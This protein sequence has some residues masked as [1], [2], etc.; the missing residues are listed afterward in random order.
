MLTA[1]ELLDQLSTSQTNIGWRELVPPGSVSD[2]GYADLLSQLEQAQAARY[3]TCARGAPYIF[4]VDNTGRGRLVQGCCNNW[5]CP[6]CGHLRALHEYGRMVN[7]A[8]ALTAAGHRLYFLTLT[9]RG[10]TCSVREAEENYLEWTNRFLTAYRTKC[11]R[12]GG[13]WHYSSVTERQRRRHP[14]SHYLITWHPSEFVH[15]RKHE[16]KFSGSKAKHNCIDSRQ[17]LDYC[18]SSGLG[19]E[20]DLTEVRNPTGCAVYIGKYLFKSSIATPW[21]PGWRRVRYSKSWPKLPHIAP[22]L[23]FPLLKLADW[24]RMAASCDI[25]YADSQITLEAAYARHITNV[26]CKST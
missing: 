6:R 2:K 13:A 11:K 12:S 17:I 19:K 24:Q 9:C 22:S 3:E 1:D 14:H 25:I 20:Y 5:L 26:V 8:K 7:G 21:P 23:A 4:F 16:T 18:L 10:K 15:R